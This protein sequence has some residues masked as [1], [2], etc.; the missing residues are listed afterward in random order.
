MRKFTSIKSNC[1]LC[2]VHTDGVVSLCSA[3]GDN[4][5]TI[6]YACS[7][8]ALPIDRSDAH[9]SG[10]EISGICGQCIS[11]KS[12]IDYSVSLYHYKAPIDYLIGQ[13]KFQQQ[14]SVVDV[15]ADLMSRQAGKLLQSNGLPD[16]I[17]PIPLHNTRI[18]KR[19]FNQSLEIV[20]R[21]AKENSIVVDLDFVNRVKKTVAQT[22]LNKEQRKKNITG[23]FELFAGS[24]AQYKHVVIVDDV[25]TTGVT[26]NELAKV[27][28]NSGVKTVGV[29]SLA[30][31]ELK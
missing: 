22:N 8:C 23:S 14:L 4:L 1:V 3:C 13:M 16:V 7:R 26:V 15:F 31:A 27:I 20:R 9:S 11:Q 25:V 18:A 28:K 17:V 5:P 10:Q 24:S 2:G 29:W 21:L 6:E 12:F 19:G 30:R